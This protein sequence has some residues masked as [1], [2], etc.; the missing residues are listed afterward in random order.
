VIVSYFNTNPKIMAVTPCM[1]IRNPKTLIQRMQAVEYL[2]GIFLRKAFGQLDAIQVTPGPF[3]IF[4]RSVFDTIGVYRKAHNTEDFEI[5]LRMHKAGLASCS[6]SSDKL[7]WDAATGTFTC[8]TDAGASGSGI[9][10][11]H[12]QYSS[13]QGGA[14]QTFATSTDSNLGI[15]ITSSGDVHT[16]A[17]T[18]S[19][20][21]AVSRGGT[22]LSTLTN[23]Q[24][25]IGGPGNT[26]VQV[27][28]SSLGL[29]TTNVAEGVN[30]YFT[31]A[32]FD[33]RLSATTSLPNITTLANLSTVNTALS[34]L[35]KTTA[36]L[37]SAATAGVDFENP[38]SF[39][40]PLQRSS[41][42]ISLAFGTTTANSWSALQEFTGNASS[43]QFT[44]TGS[45]YLA[46]LG[47]SVGIGSTTP[48][49]L[50]SL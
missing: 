7:L 31:N 44:T 4:R 18:W 28:T 33:N 48:G 17:P 34:G 23:N 37:L 32:R 2:M 21:L 6:A 47:G 42:T 14:T 41:N 39:S 46:T 24:L 38:L 26:L 36:G 25:L 10:G 30:L 12:A 13:V 8:G 5:T 45:T 43:T 50:L 11:L 19:G 35:L 15:I 16:F 29:L 9:S 20:T 1:H 40:Y 22:G 27:A 49:T 3:S